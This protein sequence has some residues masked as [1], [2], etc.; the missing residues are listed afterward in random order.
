MHA[1]SLEHASLL[2]AGDNSSSSSNN[3]STAVR[4]PDSSSRP[5]WRSLALSMTLL[6]MLSCGALLFVLL[7]PPIREPT[8]APIV[9]PTFLRTVKCDAAPPSVIV[10]SPLAMSCNCSVASSQLHSE[11]A[12]LCV[13]VVSTRMA[14]A[15]ALD[16]SI[17]RSHVHD[18]LL[19][20]CAQLPVPA[21]LSVFFPVSPHTRRSL[22]RL[23][24]CP[25]ADGCFS[26]LCLLFV[27][28]W[29]PVPE[30]N[31]QWGFGHT[32]WQLL[33]DHKRGDKD[34]Q[35]SRDEDT[36]GRT[37][38]MQQPGEFG[39][40]NQLSLE[41]RRRQGEVLWSHG[42]HGFIYHIYWFTEVPLFADFFQHLLMDGYPAV[43]FFFDYATEDWAL[44]NMPFK[45]CDADTPLE[46]VE[47]LWQWIS[48]FMRDPRYMRVHNRPILSLYAW[49]GGFCI[50]LLDRLQVMAARDAE[51]NGFSSLWAVRVLA[52]FEQGA[53][54][55]PLTPMPSV[56][57]AMEFM[58]NAVKMWTTREPALAIADRQR[59]HKVHWRG[60]PVNF[61]NR[62]RRRWTRKDGG[63][64]LHPYYFELHMR[65]E[66]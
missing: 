18:S 15:R 9:L 27:S 40:Y 65:S 56:D 30:N 24:T 7:Q 17:D 12:P 64:D 10:P 5:C 3:I 59:M 62:P 25:V 4:S 38:W 46:R 43:P 8:P 21:P 54:T 31:R 60:V 29:H 61:D 1:D 52:H 13:M 32:D 42:G 6:S 35:N 63:Y 48:P 26:L 37:G 51:L 66:Q 19:T 58:P 2:E 28:Q 14:F 23:S 57:A 41:V 50:P 20:P 49:R 33:T 44:I 36:Y 47:R 34:I 55:P 16:R 39:E 45:L 53:K 22:A 11:C